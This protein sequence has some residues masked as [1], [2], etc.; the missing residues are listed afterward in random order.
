MRQ[1]SGAVTQI[2]FKKGIQGMP[3]LKLTLFAIIL[4]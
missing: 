4:P 1:I 2:N 3:N